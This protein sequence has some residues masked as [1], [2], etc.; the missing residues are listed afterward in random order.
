M[1]PLRDH[2]AGYDVIM[3]IMMSHNNEFIIH[4]CDIIMG[5]VMLH[6]HEIIAQS[7]DVIR[8]IM[9]CHHYELIKNKVTGK[10]RSD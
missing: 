5:V 4:D 2:N 9:T 6:N 3:N 8:N 1:P 7:Y 10:N